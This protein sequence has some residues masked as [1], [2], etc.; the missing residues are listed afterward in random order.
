MML[1]ITTAGVYTTLTSILEFL[2]SMFGNVIITITGNPLLFV[3]VLISLV[4]GVVLFAVGF[5]RKMG[6][7]GVS[8]S[9]RRR[10]RG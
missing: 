9:G 8:S 4:G 2:W 5:I 3:P 6:V 10:R 1:E 7:S